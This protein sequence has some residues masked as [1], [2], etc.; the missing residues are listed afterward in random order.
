MYE[1]NPNQ[2]YRQVHIVINLIPN[3]SNLSESLGKDFNVVYTLG[4]V[5][6]NFIASAHGNAP[7]PSIKFLNNSKL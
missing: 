5:P 6:S 1:E 4:K 7:N 3:I 2:L